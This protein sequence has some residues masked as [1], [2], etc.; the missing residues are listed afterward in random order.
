MTDAQGQ[1]C[2]AVRDE[3]DRLWQDVLNNAGTTGRASSDAFPFLLPNETITRMEPDEAWPA[4]VRKRLFLQYA[5]S[6]GKRTGHPMDVFMHELDRTVRA[7]M[8]WT[9]RWQSEEDAGAAPALPTLDPDCS[10]EEQLTLV[11]LNGAALLPGE[12]QPV[13]GRKLLLAPGRARMDDR[14]LRAA[15]TPF[16]SWAEVERADAECRDGLMPLF[17]TESSRIVMVPGAA[18]LGIEVA[19]VAASAPGSIVLVLHHGPEGDRVADIVSRRGRVADILRA[20]AN[21]SIDP[22]ELRQ[23]LAEVRPNAVV[24]SHVDVDSGIAAPIDIYAPI[25]SEVAPDALLVVDGSMATGCMAERADEWRADLVF[26]DS[27]SSLGG[28]PGLVLA[29][30]SKR[31][32]ERRVRAYAVP[33]Y[34]ELSRWSSPAGAEIPP[35]LVFALRAALRSI[36]AEGIAQRA[37]RCEDTARAFREQAAAHGFGTA[38]PP[39]RESPTITVLTPPA[40]VSV[41]DLRDALDRRGIEVGIV[42]SGIVAA[43]P[44]TV[45]VEDLQ[46]FWRSVEVSH[47]Q[48]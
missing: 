1:V 30:V 33:L 8:P 22:D 37:A 25:I 28:C 47:P 11:R 45:S 3:L 34:I 24:V 19:V 36:Y 38:A 31:L 13:P 43:H 18:S 7:L 21:G 41:P 12:E 6:V 35:V 10:E 27:A 40:G 5:A 42:K 46:R 44:G 17:G 2:P 9:Q 32:F 48:S 4:Y 14:A 39:G 23:R 26:T 16:E 29:A 15:A 20:G